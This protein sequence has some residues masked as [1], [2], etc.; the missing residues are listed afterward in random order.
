MEFE[1]KVR[2]AVSLQGPLPL[3][4]STQLS[5]SLPN[6]TFECGCSKRPSQRQKILKK[7][8][9]R[10]KNMIGVESV[11]KRVPERNVV[12]NESERIRRNYALLQK[13]LSEELHA[14]MSECKDKH[15]D[16]LSDEFRKRLMQWE[17]WKA[18]TGKGQYTEEEILRNLPS[19]FGKKLI[20]WEWMKEGRKV[21]EEVGTLDWVEK[22]LEEL[23]NEKRNLISR[24]RVINERESRLVRIRNAMKRP[25]GI[26]IKTPTGKCR[27]EKLTDEFAKKIY[28]WEEKRCVRAEFS[29]IALLD[30]KYYEHDKREAHSS[31]ESVCSED[32]DYQGGTRKS[33]SRS[34]TSEDD[35]E[36]LLRKRAYKDAEA[37][38]D[39]VLRA[40]AVVVE[41]DK[42]NS[43]VFVKTNRTIFA[44]VHEEQMHSWKTTVVKQE[45]QRDHRDRPAIIN[46]YKPQPKTQ[47]TH[48]FPKRGGGGGKIP[49][50]CS[51]LVARKQFACDQD[52]TIDSFLQKSSL[53]SQAARG[54]G[55][56]SA[57]SQESP[58]T[59][60]RLQLPRK[61]T[62]GGGFP[63]CGSLLSRSNSF[64]FGRKSSAL[65]VE[66]E[67]SIG[68]STMSVCSVSKSKSTGSI[69]RKF[70]RVLFGLVGRRE[71][72][73][74]VVDDKMVPGTRVQCNDYHESRQY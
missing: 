14:R 41:E 43:T 28:E 54:S 29:T 47:L 42:E 56:A 49:V 37:Q 22:N 16:N 24:L 34:L 50:W 66:P 55:A 53:L 74:G 59:S 26:W 1:F 48:K 13:R 51:P 25:E 57:G 33:S 62:I 32:Y 39:V 8:W 65:R 3:V 31:R 6:V 38:T 35:E 63:P 11:K 27:V 72:A 19:E 73:K 30:P 9:D 67:S 64:G 45:Q 68:S 40:Q 52:Y 69:S 23:R 10:M 17:M 7:T 71:S 20:E 18:S 44:P 36:E 70:G 46:A 61:Y 4:L 2:R 21:C 58:D 15:H 5:K 12:D 60:N